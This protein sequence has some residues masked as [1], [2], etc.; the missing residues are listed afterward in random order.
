M[1]IIYLIPQGG[2]ITDLRSDT[3]WGMLCWGIRHLWGESELESF[4]KKAASGHPDFVITSTFPFKQHGDERI[5]F[6]PNPL[7]LP[8]EAREMDVKKA[9]AEARAR[10]DLKEVAWLGLE[11]FEAVLHGK[12]TS[13]DLL[14]RIRAARDLRKTAEEDGLGYPPSGQTVRRTA[15]E[16]KVFSQTHNTID[17][18]QGGTLTKLD[19]DN[20]R[21]G[22]LFHADEIFW[23]D[24]DDETSESNTGLFFL[25]EGTDLTKL[26]PVLNLFR[27]VGLG[28]DRSS[29]KGFFD[30]E[31]LDFAPSEPPPSS[32]NALINLSLFCPTEPELEAF[33]A[34]NGALQYLLEKREGY[35]GG[36]ALHPKQ[37]RMY[38]KEGSVFARPSEQMGRVMGCVRQQEFEEESKPD[39]EVWENGFAFMLNLNWK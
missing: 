23:R 18:L 34:S 21:A 1:K 22:Q 6:F 37:P 39:H 32:A 3:L 11:D 8:P 26:A 19:S 4:I 10:K 33:K 36:R 15:P 14:V 24:P 12:L 25:A 2:Y 35:V 13:E 31:I 29:G 5:P 27:H 28:A 38:F 20:N 16:R 30:F 7:V 17:R 9:L